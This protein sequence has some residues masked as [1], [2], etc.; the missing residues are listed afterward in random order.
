LLSSAPTRIERIAAPTIAFDRP[1]SKRR[2][3]YP[4]EARVKRGDRGVNPHAAKAAAA[5]TGGVPP[6][7]FL[8][9]LGHNDLCPCGS[10]KR[11]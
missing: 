7:E 9:K 5:S 1:L 2:H 11:F 10:R 6:K 8:E 3:G 4:S